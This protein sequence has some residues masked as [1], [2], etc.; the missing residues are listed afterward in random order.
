MYMTFHTVYKCGHY[1]TRHKLCEYGSKKEKKLCDGKENG[2]GNHSTKYQFMCEFDGCN[3]KKK[4]KREGPEGK[5]KVKSLHRRT[6]MTSRLNRNTRIRILG[7]ARRYEKA[8]RCSCRSERY[9]FMYMKFLYFPSVLLT[10]TLTPAKYNGLGF[11][12]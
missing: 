12:D 5:D 6:L 9:K 1:K 7:P 2:H 3:G 4:L 8:L 10:M 11:P